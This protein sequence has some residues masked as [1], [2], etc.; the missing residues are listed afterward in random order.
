MQDRCKTKQ[1]ENSERWRKKESEVGDKGDVIVILNVIDSAECAN[2]YNCH[3]IIVFIRSCIHLKDSANC[4][5]LPQHFHKWRVPG[6]GMKEYVLRGVYC[7]WAVC[8]EAFP[9]SLCCLFSYLLASTESEIMSGCS[10][11]RIGEKMFCNGFHL[12]WT[13]LESYY[14]DGFSHLWIWSRA[15]QS[16]RTKRTVLNDKSFAFLQ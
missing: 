6:F 12:I 13:Q 5:I 10:V 7:T 4:H 14:R 3:Q 11:L 16:T 8:H 1:K 9:H 15:M 2:Q